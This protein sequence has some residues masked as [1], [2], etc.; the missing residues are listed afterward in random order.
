MEA[1]S[2]SWIPDA[3]TGRGPGRGGSSWTRSTAQARR[4]EGRWRVHGAVSARAPGGATRRAWQLAELHRANRDGG[5]L[6]QGEDSSPASAAQVVGRV[7]TVVVTIASAVRSVPSRVGA[8]AGDEA[9]PLLLRCKRRRSGSTTRR[10]VLKDAG[11]ARSRDRRAARFFCVLVRD[12][13]RATMGSRL[14]VP[15]RR[16]ERMPLAMRRGDGCLDSRRQ[17][18][19]P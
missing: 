10:V 9:V 19:P 16:S 5:R 3:A 4:F 17:R 6:P 13:P 14:D 15:R 1:G 11:T 12:R 8:L 18:P 7:A 2:R